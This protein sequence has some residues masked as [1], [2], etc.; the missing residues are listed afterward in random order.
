MAQVV[1]IAGPYSGK[2]FHDYR[3][4][5]EIDR[6]IAQAR[7]AAAKLASAQVR[8]FCPHL[9]SAHFEVIAPD[10]PTSFWYDLDNHFLK[11][12]CTGILLLPGWWES[13]GSK[14]E[15]KLAEELRLPVFYD[16]EEAIQWAQAPVAT[17]KAS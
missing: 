5:E 8:Y 17:A 9:H 1:Y 4:Y 11:F 3:A 10:V 2:F 16:V 14:A 7:E 15:K 12:A 13:R 6:N